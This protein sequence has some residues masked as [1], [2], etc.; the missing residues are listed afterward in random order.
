M[1]ESYII[2]ARVNVSPYW[3][4]LPGNCHMPERSSESLKPLGFCTPREEQLTVM[5]ELASFV[6]RVCVCVCEKADGIMI[7]TVVMAKNNG[8][9]T[10]TSQA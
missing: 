6:L 4:R 1:D 10:N 2:L 9:D 3:N 5:I 7:M 8:I